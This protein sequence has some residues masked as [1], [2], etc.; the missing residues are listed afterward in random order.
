MILVL[1]LCIICS[2]EADVCTH[3]GIKINTQETISERYVPFEGEYANIGH[4]IYKT[5]EEVVRCFDCGA[6]LSRSEPHEV[7]GG[8]F[9]H[10]Y[11]NDDSNTC[12][13]C[14]HVSTCLHES[15]T[16]YKDLWYE[17]SAEEI[18]GDDLYHLATGEGAD[19]DI[20]DA[21]LREFHYRGETIINEYGWEVTIVTDRKPHRY[22]D[23]I[24]SLC[25]HICE[26]SGEVETEFE[27]TEITG[28][29]EE[30]EGNDHL[31]NAIGNGTETLRCSI[32]GKVVSTTEKQN[33][34]WTQSHQYN[35][36]GE[37]DICG[38]QCGHSS[39]SDMSGEIRT[40]SAWQDQ[41]THRTLRV[42]DTW[43]KCD[44]CGAITDK[45]TMQIDGEYSS[46]THQ[47]L[48][49]DGMCDLCGGMLAATWGWNDEGRVLFIIG[50]GAMPD[51]SSADEVPWHKLGMKQQIDQVIVGANISHIGAYAFA[52]MENGLRIEMDQA[53]A[54]TASSMAFSGTNGAV[55]RYYTEWDEESVPDNTTAKW[56][57]LPAD[58]RD[59]MQNSL[60]YFP[61]RGW[62]YSRNNG[63]EV[64]ETPVNVAQAKELTYQNR[65]VFLYGIPTGED[66]SLISNGGAEYGMQIYFGQGCEYDG[67]F[68]LTIPEDAGENKRIEVEMKAPGLKVCVRDLRPRTWTDPR[69]ARM[70]NIWIEDGT[71]DV[72]ADVTE[73]L[74]RDTDG[75]RPE[76]TIHGDVGTMHF[77]EAYKGDLTVTGRVLYGTY[78]GPAMLAVPNIGNVT[79]DEIMTA[80]ITQEAQ[81]EE[82]YTKVIDGGIVNAECLNA[83]MPTLA[84]FDYLYYYYPTE[85]KWQFR[86]LAKSDSEFGGYGTE[87]EEIRENYNDQFTLKDIIWG[88]S[89]MLTV[90]NFGEINSKTVVINGQNGTGLK[91]VAVTNAK[92]KINCPLNKLTAHGWWNQ[93]VPA[94]IEINNT[95]DHAFINLHETESVITLG[96]GGSVLSGFWDRQINGA[97]YFGPVSGGQDLFRDGTLRTLNW[98]QGQQ[99]KAIL[100]G[101]K[102][103]TDAL[104]QENGKTG[105][106]EIS[107]S[108]YN[109]MEPEEQDALNELLNGTADTVANV[110]DVSVKAYTV[111]E[112]GN[113][114]QG[115]IVEELTRPVGIAV[116]NTTGGSAYVVRLHEDENDEMKAEQVSAVTN[117]ST[118]P[119]MSSL[120]SK[121][122]VVEYK[123]N[124]VDP[125]MLTKKLI[126]P[127]DTKRIEAGAFIGIDAE[128]VFIPQGC[129]YIGAGAFTNCDNLLYVE[130]YQGTKIEED[131]FGKTGIVIWEKGRE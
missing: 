100:A 68:E 67:T 81:E 33:Q 53:A 114:D 126:L 48:N 89:T 35:G 5:V 51:F 109:A 120:F 124:A 91:E 84:D 10:G 9:Q 101:D 57:Y 39:C 42:Q 88:D 52:G 21:C 73:L 97:R 55:C 99:T 30:I 76:I 131:A 19:Y 32:C 72:Y 90:S 128:A 11:E 44:D 85:N 54:P 38:H 45:R 95:V 40:V 62:L 61:D 93:E 82:P 3:Q 26:H 111:D 6:E 4:D 98:K 83:A 104:K 87:I 127:E 110:F 105:S 125:D 46:D 29:T 41:N 8:N 49:G 121:Y 24:C 112:Q 43:K 50:S 74:L 20:C 79:F 130:Y 63:I 27:I 123:G 119:F 80:K 56:I 22:E 60:V 118:I 1:C 115:T 36:D 64:V 28:A 2:A 13:A 108:S 78:Y 15:V 92:V 107:D 129:E 86:L 65:S 25:E 102:E 47:D 70:R 106:M 17:I 37:C 23:G 75:C 113:A 66:L 34:A 71:L 31:H 7:Y 96:T 103:V 77:Y 58:N 12:I 122:V 59:R 116:E 117:G 14:G 18:D 94:L 16:P 69:N